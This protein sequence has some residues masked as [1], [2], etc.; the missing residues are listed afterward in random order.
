MALHIAPL[1]LRIGEET[2]CY[3]HIAPLGLRTEDETYPQIS[4]CPLI[5]DL[6][7]YHHAKD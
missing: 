4:P 6:L 1:G 5:P 2:R 3:K 7:S